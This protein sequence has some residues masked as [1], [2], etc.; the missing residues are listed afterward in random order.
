M[1]YHVAHTAGKVLTR[2]EPPVFQRMGQQKVSNAAGMVTTKEVKIFLFTCKDAFPG[3]PPCGRSKYTQWGTG[4]GALAKHLRKCHP[5][6][7]AR[8]LG[9]NEVSKRTNSMVIDGDVVVRI[10]FEAAF[11]CHIRVRV[12]DL[13]EGYGCG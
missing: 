8:M 4:T 3:D 1:L 5:A 6:E 2:F 10:S 13:R 7:W 12:P 9:G 11:P